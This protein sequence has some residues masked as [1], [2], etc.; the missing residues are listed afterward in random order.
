Q[1]ITDLYDEKNGAFLV[2]YPIWLVV[3]LGVTGLAAFAITGFTGYDH[4]PPF[5]EPWI[6]YLWFCA[7]VITLQASI[8]RNRALRVP[9]VVTLIV[10]LICIALVGVNAFAPLLPDVIRRLLNLQ[11][12]LRGLA[13]NAWTYTIL[14]FGIILIFWV[15]SIRRWSRRAR[16]LAPTDAIPLLPDETAESLSEKDPDTLEEML[17]GHLLHGT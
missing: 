13:T 14:N 11:E 1:A 4:G 5:G 6:L 8:F 10:T 15:D 16:G 7:L 3:A 17:S 2:Q 9:L 12:T